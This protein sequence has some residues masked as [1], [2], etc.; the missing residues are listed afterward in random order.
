MDS[1]REQAN[2]RMRVGAVVAVLGAAAGIPLSISGA[3]DLREA[4]VARKERPTLRI[5]PGLATL[6]FM[7]R[8]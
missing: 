5:A 1:A 4:R 8:F 7:G 2:L 3:R 6:S